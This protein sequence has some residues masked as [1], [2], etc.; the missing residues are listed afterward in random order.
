MEKISKKRNPNIALQLSLRFLKE[1]FRKLKQMQE[2]Y[3]SDEIQESKELVIQRA[4]WIALIIEVGKLFD[5]FNSRHKKVISLKQVSFFQN[6]PWKNKIDSI[7]GEV[8]ISKIIQTRKTF[9]AH[10][11]EDNIKPVSIKEICDS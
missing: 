1:Y 10:W 3:P 5:D 4:L 6:E 11:S 7:Y 2:S 8:I 9:T